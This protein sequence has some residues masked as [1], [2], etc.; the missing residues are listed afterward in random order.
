MS[1]RKADQPSLPLQLSEGVHLNIPA[2]VYFDAG[3]I[4]SSDLKGLYWQPESWWFSSW[5]N[6]RR[7]VRLKSAARGAQ[8]MG[9][10][11]HTLVLEGEDVYE[12]RFAVEP[13]ADDPKWLM[14]PSQI[15]D[16]LKRLG[17]DPRKA[18]GGELMRMA[19][20]AGL[21]PRIWERAVTSFESAKRAGRLYM[22]EDDD[23]RIRDTGRVILEND[24]LA[25]ALRGE[26][27]LTEVAVFWRRPED[28]YTLLRAKF[29]RIRVERIFDLKSLGN[30][31]GRDIDGAIR[32]TIEQNEYG[33]QRRF[34]HEAFQVL[35]EFVQDGRIHFWA[36]DGELATV[37]PSDRETLR[38]IAQKPDA[39]WIWVFAQLRNDAYGQERAPMAITRAH[40][41]EGRIW[42]EAGEKIEDALASFRRLRSEHGLDKPWSRVDADGKE[43]VDS[44][45]RGRVKREI[46]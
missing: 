33:I 24:R 15:K 8:V 44:D 45:I 6:P 14:N 4:G 40:R 29:D 38:A 1:K 27:G 22:T 39:I 25:K 10:A 13:D 12:R 32:E 9:E 11:L 21:G 37:R 35:C 19:I 5:L 41:P 31:R 43:L 3:A 16:E 46:Q 34:Y 26:G 30:W 17:K 28:P 42:D 2:N 36:E 18:W 23:F 20:H 7:R